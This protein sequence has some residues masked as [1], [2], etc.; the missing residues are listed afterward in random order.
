[1][2]AIDFSPAAIEVTRRQVAKYAPDGDARYLLADVRRDDLPECDVTLVMGL[3]PYLTDLEGFLNRALPKTNLFYCLYVDPMHWANRIRRGIPFLNVR[4]LRA[5]GRREVT[6]IYRAHNAT[7]I[8]RSD[9]ASGYIDLV[10]SCAR[11]G[12]S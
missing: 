6:E 11:K 7:L 2:N 4:S 10:A 9:F 12:V 5:Y 3:T 8:D 1:V